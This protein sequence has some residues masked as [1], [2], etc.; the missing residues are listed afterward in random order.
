MAKRRSRHGEGGRGRYTPPTRRGTHAKVNAASD[1]HRVHPAVTLT[2]AGLL[3]TTGL[4]GLGMLT[5]SAGG[6]VSPPAS[7]HA[8]SAGSNGVAV[9]G[10]QNTGSQTAN[11]SSPLTTAGESTCAGTFGIGSKTTSISTQASASPWKVL[12]GLITFTG[13]LTALDEITDEFDLTPSGQT[14]CFSLNGERGVSCQA[15]TS[16]S[17]F[18][19]C[20]VEVR[21]LA[22][23]LWINNYTASYLGNSTYAHSSE[24]GSINV[25]FGNG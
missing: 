17:G 1:G 5:T 24:T 9:A 8:W 18:A 13:K 6:A 22:A 7:A 15:V 14:I 4:F 23:L 19:E 11:G 16:S 20:Q 10:T 3:A 12:D 2:G 21:P 25:R